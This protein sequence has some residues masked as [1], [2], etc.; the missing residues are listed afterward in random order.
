M[1]KWVYTFGNGSA[2]GASEMRNLLGREG[3]EPCGDEFARFACAARFHD[4][5]GGM[6]LVL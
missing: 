2:E 6:Q 1:S 5:H 3:C 4:H